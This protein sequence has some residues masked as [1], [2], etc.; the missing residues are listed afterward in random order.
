MALAWK[1]GWV[2]ALRGSNPLSSAT[3]TSTIAAV[4]ERPLAYVRSGPASPLSSTLQKSYRAGMST[5][6]CRSWVAALGT[7]TALLTLAGTASG[8]PDTPAIS[9][10]LQ[11]RP[12]SSVDPALDLGPADLAETRAT[13][14]LQPGVTLTR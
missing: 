10:T 14:A 1:A 13:S 9:H 8:A 5:G 6:T 4:V 7:V 2:N 3:L 11:A 12:D